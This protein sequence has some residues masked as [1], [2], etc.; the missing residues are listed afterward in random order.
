MGGWVV[1]RRV[2]FQSAT[3]LGDHASKTQFNF[4]TTTT[5][6]IQDVDRAVRRLEDDGVSLYALINNAVR[7]DCWGYHREEAA[8]IHHTGL[9]N[10]HLGTQTPTYIHRAWAAARPST[11]Y[12]SRTTSGSCA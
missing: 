7:A 3:A 2:G 8:S 12:R 1:A 10:L 5:K 4:A 9:S 11:G 6:T